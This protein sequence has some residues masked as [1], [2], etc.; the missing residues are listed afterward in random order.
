MARSI[1]QVWETKQLC[2][3]LFSALQAQ[4]RSG[5][6]P[7]MIFAGG[8]GFVNWQ[9][10]VGERCLILGNNTSL[11]ET[12]LGSE[13]DKSVRLSSKRSLHPKTPEIRESAS[14]IIIWKPFSQGSE[15]C[16]WCQCSRNQDS[17]A[18]TRIL[19]P[20]RSIQKKKLQDFTHKKKTP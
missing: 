5:H 9:I 14:K 8:H 3:R 18:S 19:T 17:N 12:W 7:K 11:S 16:F 1:S 2:G 13:Y 10:T 4:S 15:S 20:I 6:L